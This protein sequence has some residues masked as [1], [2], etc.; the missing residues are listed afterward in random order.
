MRNSPPIIVAEPA[1][2][3]M[4]SPSCANVLSNFK[5]LMPQPV[6]RSVSIAILDLDGTLL[7]TDAIVGE[8]LIV[9]LAEYYKRWDGRETPKVAGK[10]PVEAAAAIVEDYGLSCST[11]E[12][13]SEITPMFGDQ[14]SKIKALPGANRLIKHLRGNGV[15]MALA[16]NSPQESIELKISFH[17][18]W[19]EPFA[20][21]TGGDEVREGK[22]CP[23]IFLAASKGLE[24][25]PSKTGDRRFPARSYGRQ[26]CWYGGPKNGVCLLPKIGEDTLPIEP[27]HIGGPVIKG[28]GRGSK[29]LG[30]PTANL[31]TDGY[32]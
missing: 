31:S 29:V 30:I 8:V 9:Y 3:F 26:S 20:V 23:E 17:E 15:P 25:E 11:E 4:I 32:S 2:R 16:L 6:K 14:W 19:K 27:W 18:R 21:I 13:I 22:P 7:N 1:S 5:M 28:F 12:L 10:T 24:L